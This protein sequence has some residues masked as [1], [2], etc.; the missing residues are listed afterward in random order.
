MSAA[1]AC[2]CRVTPMPNRLIK[3]SICTSDNLDALTWFEEVFFYRLIVNCD[4][5]GRMDARPAILRAR[6]FP[7]KTVTD[8][9][10]TKALESLRSAAMIDLYTVDGRTFLQMRTWERHQQIRAKKSKCPSPEDGK[11]QDDIIC[12]QAISDDGK[13]PRN[14]IQSES[15][16]ESNA[17]EKRARTRFV[18]PSIE[19][20]TAYFEQ[21]GGN[22]AQARRFVDHY[23]A[24]GWKAGRNPM[25]DWQASARNWIARDAQYAAEKNPGKSE[26]LRHSEAERK[27]TYS[28]A[29]LDFD[30]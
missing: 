16:S 7:L 30:G 21:I 12:N 5:F 4:D 15:E 18:P 22:A 8:A 13:C 29:I 9:Q 14:P 3:E 20:A 24:N 25:R 1:T 28:A 26:M 6:L 23:T 27:A 19:E 17:R 11:V 10:I 2:A